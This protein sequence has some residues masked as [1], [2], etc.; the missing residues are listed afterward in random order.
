MSGTGVLST[1]VAQTGVGCSVLVIMSLPVSV[2]P[3]P[4]GRWKQLSA[5]SLCTRS[6]EVGS[7]L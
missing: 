7:R 2:G 6:G 3:L 4:E 1:G 5:P